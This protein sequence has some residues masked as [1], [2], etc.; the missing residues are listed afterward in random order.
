MITALGH[1]C[2]IRSCEAR[3][4][5][6]NEGIDDWGKC[7]L[8][9][10]FS[11]RPSLTAAAKVGAFSGHICHVLWQQSSQNLLPQ[12]MTTYDDRTLRIWVRKPAIK[13]GETVLKICCRT[14][15]EGV[16]GGAEPP[17]SSGI[18]IFRSSSNRFRLLR[19]H[20]NQR[21]AAQPDEA[22]AT[23]RSKLRDSY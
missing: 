22:Q 13:I 5:A 8:A 3:L 18:T 7:G 2:I 1:G 23:R 14:A 9:A 17:P 16:W 15:R 6:S 11:G 12:Y 20:K 19:C 21:L 4:V 10:C